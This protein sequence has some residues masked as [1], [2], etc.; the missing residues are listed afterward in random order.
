M[1]QSFT[2]AP[3]GLKEELKEYTWAIGAE[4][5]Y[6]NSFALRAGYFNESNLKGA[7][8]FFTL[9]TGFKFRSSRIDMSYLFNASN[10]NNPLE[11]TLR[12]SLTFDFGDTYQEN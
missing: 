1:F 3:G 12:F 5:L 4:Y 10:I 8:K 7:R 2:D 9:G 11:N 6:D